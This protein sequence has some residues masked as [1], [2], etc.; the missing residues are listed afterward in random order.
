MKSLLLLILFVFSGAAAA[1]PLPLA[2]LEDLDGSPA[3]S[4]VDLARWRQAVHEL[5]R[6][7]ATPAGWATGR[8]LTEQARLRKSKGQVPLAV[9]W[10]RYEGQ[11][12]AGAPVGRQV[13]AFTPLQ[14]AVYHGENLL[15]SLDGARI[16][17]HGA[18]P[19]A[20]LTLDA[21][22]G[23]GWRKLEPGTALPVSYA[24]TGTR[25]LR[26]RAQLDDG[27]LIHA[28]AVLEVKRLTT[29]DPTA[30]WPIT[31]SVGYGGA[32][33]TGQAYLY[34]AEGHAAPVN[35]VVVVEGFDLDNSMDWPV[36]YD[37][38]NQADLLED[39]RAAGHDAVVLDF[40]EAT[41]PIQRNA[42]VLTELLAQ[43]RAAAGGEATLALVGASMGGLV[44]RY[45]LLWLEDQGLD[46][47]VRTF[48]SFD[49]PQNGANIP[50]GL[51]H[52]LDFFQDESTEAAYLLSR[53]STPAAR[54]MLLY[55][56]SA[57][58]SPG[59]DPLYGAL[60][61][62]LAALGDWPA[63]PRLVAVANGSGLNQDQGF[64][65]GAQLIR[66]EYR[67]LLVDIDGNV[68]AV[69][70][71]GPQVIFD[72]MLNVIWPL[73]DTYRTITVGGSLPWDGA[74]GG[75]RASLAQM[76]TTAVP[77]GD[78][79]ALHPAH[80]FIPTVSALALE[81]ADPFFDIAG[82]G[83]LAAL[84]P[85]DALYWPAQNQEHIAVTPENKAWFLSEIL[86]APSAVGDRPVPA[87]GPVLYAA[88]P[89]PFNPSTTI[90]F[91][92]EEREA[93]TLEVFDLAGR[94][95]S[96]LLQGEILEAGRHSAVW[97]GVTRD[98]SAAPSGPYF[99]RLRAA[100]EVRTGR[101]TLLK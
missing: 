80:C 17:S 66:Y 6:S 49:S 8:Q 55:H 22:D 44:S 76:D 12:A 41:D 72:G 23:L 46:H 85:F 65:P 26:L 70:Q 64:A 81:V 68:W 1:A 61:G 71:G 73:P 87:A 50:L 101:L 53:L 62:D 11:D 10:A 60:R 16:L 47:G 94:L 59:A 15:F 30:I 31:A 27:S 56:L 43:V 32:A 34:L 48:V 99:C 75:F 14:Q 9:V 78:I 19:L 5:S 40:T 77:Y 39:L 25:T 28:Q 100:G 63:A 88:A 84:S 7:F 45:A 18:P 83:D 20:E 36:L 98:G 90:A 33:G 21:D 89:N 92:L 95:V 93:V 79:Q 29:P 82:A 42:L 96:T 86:T 52:W 51:Q 97:T 3:S 2:H 54:Q 4:R 13:F 35:P 38:L 37:L 74:P 24:A 58:V 91:R 57:P 67:S 69:P